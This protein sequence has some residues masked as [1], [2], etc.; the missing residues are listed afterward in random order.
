MQ[1][2]ARHTG[3][4]QFSSWEPERPWRKGKAVAHDP[5]LVAAVKR[6]RKMISATFRSRR[7]FLPIDHACA[8]TPVE[9]LSKGEKG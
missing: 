7:P 2:C 9:K 5:G 3:I 1:M 4:L 8:I 6:T